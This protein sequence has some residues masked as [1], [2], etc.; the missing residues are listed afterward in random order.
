M[1]LNFK[2]DLPND[3]LVKVDRMSMAN[4]LETR[5]PF[6]D[7]RLVEFMVQVDKKVKMQGWE[8]KSILRNTI[9]KK[10]PP[11]VLAA[12]KKG[13]G[14]PLRE[15]FKEDSFKNNISNNLSNL[16]KI[17]NSAGLINWLKRTGLVK[18]TMVTLFGR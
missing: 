4:S 16:N 10:L 15:W 12:P 7:H 1:Y 3:Y 14:I 18:K 5:V 13:F 6:L 17:L 8:R 2:H 9:G 11:N